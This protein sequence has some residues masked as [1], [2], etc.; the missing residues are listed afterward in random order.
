M[1]SGIPI[2]YSFLIT[3]T[4]ESTEKKEHSEDTEPHKKV[5]SHDFFSIRA[6]WFQNLGHFFIAKG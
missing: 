5:M 1:S 4:T 2:P 3:L 6:L